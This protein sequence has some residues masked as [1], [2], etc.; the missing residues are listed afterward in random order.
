MQARFGVVSGGFS[1]CYGGIAMG[2]ENL[3]ITSKIDEYINK[4]LQLSSIKIKD[5]FESMGAR[6]SSGGSHISGAKWALDFLMK[7]LELSFSEKLLRLIA[8]KGRKPA[9]IYTKA[10]LTKSHFSKIKGDDDYHP[11]KETALAFAIALHLN[12]EETTD[13]IGR[14]GYTLSHSS[15]SDL[16]VEYFIKNRI[17]SIDD[18]NIQLDLRGFKPLTNWRKSKTE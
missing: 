15:K 17:Y 11:S 8:E 1:A 2:K 10:G 7:K 16:I 4:H 9:D 18:L 13:L 3:V 14:A 5:F 6:H 12:L